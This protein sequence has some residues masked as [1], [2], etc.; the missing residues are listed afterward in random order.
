MLRCVWL[1]ALLPALAHAQGKFTARIAGD[2]TYLTAS[3]SSVMRTVLVADTLWVW[4]THSRTHGDSVVR[5]VIHGDSAVM[6]AHG[7]AVWAPTRLAIV[8][9]RL[10][11]DVVKMDARLR[12]LRAVGAIVP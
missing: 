3:D 7:R 4:S 8:P 10:A 12:E 6:C 11:L 5:W 9:R 1:V 2:T